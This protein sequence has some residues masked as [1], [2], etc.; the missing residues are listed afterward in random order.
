MPI[1]P[2]SSIAARSV[3]QLVWSVI[4]NTQTNVACSVFIA[5]AWANYLERSNNIS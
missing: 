4:A 5:V 3:N 1:V 2:G